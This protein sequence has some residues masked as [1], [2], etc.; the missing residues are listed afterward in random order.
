MIAAQV[1]AYLVFV[2]VLTYLLYWVDKSQAE[3]QG[4]RI[5]EGTLLL[6][7]IAGGS[8]AA[9]LACHKL[10]HKTRKQP[11]RTLLYLILALQILFAGA[12]VTPGQSLL[13][14]VSGRIFQS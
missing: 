13:E 9:F 14:L 8:P 10:R 1:G 2:N 5:S 6:L 4:Y 11:F 12:L 3:Q 7:A